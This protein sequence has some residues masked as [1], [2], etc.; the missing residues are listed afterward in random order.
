[1]R[2]VTRSA[3]ILA[4]LMLTASVAQA[5]TTDANSSRGTADLSWSTRKGITGPG[6]DK[7]GGGALSVQF[8]ADLDPVADT[9]KPLL[10]VA[11]K[12]VVLQASWHDN[13]T[14]QLSPVDSTTQDGA[15]KV[16]HTLAPHVKLFI[17]ALGFNLTY[18]YNAQ[19]LVGDLPGSSFNY[20]GV[21]DGTFIPWAMTNYGIVKVTAPP[22]SDAVL[23]SKKLEDIIGGDPNNPKITGTLAF[24]ATTAPT[25]NYATTEIVVDNG[26]PITKTSK[27]WSIATVDEDALDIPTMVKGQ[28]T[29]SG[30]LFGRPSISITS[31]AGIQSPIPLTFEIDALGTELPYSSETNGNTPIDVEFPAQMVHIPLPNVKATN[32]LD[33]GS[34]NVGEV[35]TKQSEIKNTGELEAVLSIKSSDPQFKVSVGD[36]VMKAKDTFAL[37]IEFSPA[38]EGPQSADITVTSNDPNEPVQVIHVTGNG[39]KVTE[40]PAPTNEPEEST[41]RADNG[42]GC[43]TAPTPSGFAGFGLVG[44][45]LAAMLRRRRG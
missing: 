1:M 22:L 15:V 24:N 19:A 6:S 43:R 38:N 9:T 31:I 32:T 44:L 17:N 14:I 37:D 40:P 27:S 35:T 16:M 25:F 3:L 23:V 33:V 20:Q 45:A 2:L 29:Y 5:A 13:K 18:D 11:M 34:A 7:L 41:P 10:S 26:Q 8:S 4:A 28:I 12:Q 39:T 30:S 42:C 36:K 21:G